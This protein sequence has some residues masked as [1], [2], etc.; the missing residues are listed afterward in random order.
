MFFLD[1]LL[2]QTDPHDP[3]TRSFIEHM[4]P[5][6]MQEYVITS[7]KGGDHAHDLGRDDETR[8]KFEAKPDQNMVSH[9]LNGI[10]PTLRLLHILDDEGIGPYHFSDLESRIYILAYLMHDIDKIVPHD[11]SLKGVETQDRDAIERAKKSIAE[12]LQRCNAEA[13][14]PD[15]M[16][17]LEDITYLVV[18]TQQMW[19][20]NLHTYLWN[21]QL[22]ERRILL[23]RRLCTYSDHIAYLITSPSSIVLD[24]QAKNLNIILGELSDNTLTFTY[25][26]LR[27]V[28]GL[29]TNVINES[30]VDLFTKGNDGIWPYLFF[31][32]GVVYL[33]RASQQLTVNHKQVTET[34]RERL[35]QICA[36]RIISQAPGFKFSI[37]GIAKHPGYYFEFLTLEE[38]IELLTD[39]TIRRTTN[40]IT[41]VPFAKLRQM[42]EHSEIPATITTD[43][44]PDKM[45]G[46]MSRFLSV[47]FTTLLDLLDKKQVELRDRVTQAVVAHLALTPYWSQS[48]TIPNR[49]GVEYRWFWLAACFMRDHQGMDIYDGEPN[50]FQIFRST[51]ALVRELA[52]DELRQRLPQRYLQHLPAYLESNIEL[53]LSVQEGGALPDF[54]GEL[55]R[56][57]GAKTKGRKLICTLCN[58]AYPTEEQAD[59]AVLFQPWVYKN[60][61]SLYA[62]KNAG[63]ICTICAL[64]LM[65][66]QILQKS[67]LRLT[68]SKFESLKTKYISIYPNFFFTQETGAMVEGIIQ[69]LQDINFFS[70]RRQ[71]N[72]ED[73]TI[74]RLLELEVFTAAGNESQPPPILSLHDDE[75]EEELSEPETSVEQQERSY[76]KFQ[77]TAYPGIYMF[78]M[79]AAK[80]D[81]DTSSWA[82]PAFLALALPLVSNTKVVLSE[83]PIPLFS[84]GHDFRETVILDAP[85]AYLTR[86]L[87][88]NRIRVN[89]LHAQL[90]RLTSI[91]RINLDTYAKQGKP[92][93]KHLSGITRDLA[94]D[95]LFLFSYLRKQQ[96]A[97]QR[98]TLRTKRVQQYMHA[99]KNVLF[100][101]VQEEN[102]S[103]VEQCVNLYTRFYR[104]GYESHSIVRP[105][106][107]V[108]RAIITSPRDI[109]PE[110][111]LWQLQGEVTKWL[112]RVRS[113]QTSGYAMFWGKDITEKEIQAVQDFISYFYKEVFVTY[114]EGERGILR[115]RLNRFKDGC[116]AY[117]VYQRAMKRIQEQSE[118][119]PEELEEMAEV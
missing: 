83:L 68:G 2:K 29:L 6:L 78:G 101:N 11:P 48:L 7:A 89:T 33:Q 42:Q 27:E 107:I 96:R 86:L 50:L 44:V 79:R 16:T 43:F 30:L 91:Y 63:G 22:R 76:I 54:Q 41:V 110:D 17:Y 98:D 84:S 102:M 109:E 60:K 62:G 80:D 69:Q 67:T 72:G 52:G 5:N 85:H 108:A 32:D 9:Q 14:F 26:Q 74:K 31:A 36:Q 4:I 10:F 28:R 47:V 115:S 61:L 18:N 37:Q 24:N 117:Y 111:L 103:K 99:Y 66:R 65:L 70:I 94:T 34:V 88:D 20:T 58:S 35:R 59:N 75:E 1:F 114:C 105:V 19:G 112:N 90:S 45:T 25:H 92:E 39:F 82:M 57:A 81:D 13:F 97:E 116:E 77:Q 56:Y 71:L 104:G 49:G 106:D 46:M 95:P 119:T 73:L 55:A 12:Q 23:L 21:F 3:V 100:T 93:W 38:Y 51:L 87:R 8:R 113:K 15:F 40:D 64:E 118:P 53:P